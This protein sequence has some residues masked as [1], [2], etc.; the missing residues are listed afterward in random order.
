MPDEPHE[1]WFNGRQF[2]KLTDGTIEAARLMNARTG[3]IAWFVVA[4]PTEALRKAFGG[5][6]GP[7]Q[8]PRTQG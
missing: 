7:R 2:R 4:T 5:R 6:L 1:V 3:E 8:P